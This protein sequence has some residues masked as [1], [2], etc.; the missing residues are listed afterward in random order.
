MGDDRAAFRA[1]LKR[2]HIQVTPQS[3]G[4]TT[5]EV[6]ECPY[7]GA[8]IT[9]AEIEKNAGACPECGTMVTGSLLFD[10][11][12]EDHGDVDDEFTEKDGSEERGRSSQP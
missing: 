2:R 11:P 10:E 9:M 7:C 1:E 8:E 3:G 12:A 5:M 4:G 6:V